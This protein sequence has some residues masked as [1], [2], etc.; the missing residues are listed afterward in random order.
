M[1]ES[2]AVDVIESAARRAAGAHALLHTLLHALPLYVREAYYG[3]GGV[4]SIVVELAH[5]KLAHVWAR[6]VASFA[7]H[8]LDGELALIV[9]SLLLA[10]QLLDAH[11]ALMLDVELDDEPMYVCMYVCMYERA[12]CGAGWYVCMYERAG[13]GAG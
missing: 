4:G 13:C 9:E 5:V 11:V 12:G 6:W 3:V 1:C 8:C 2:A 10:L 7:L